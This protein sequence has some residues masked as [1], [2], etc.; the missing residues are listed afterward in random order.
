MIH[1][2]YVALAVREFERY[3]GLADRAVAQVSDEQFFAVPGNGDNS[4]AVIVKHMAGNMRSRWENF[5][6]SDG[7]KP[8]RN[9]DAEFI[10]TPDDTRASLWANWE[11]SWRILFSELRPL[12]DKDLSRVVTI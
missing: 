10:I 7:E 11:S 5:L 2:D 12:T 6:T 3:R 8:D 4:I 9:R 1:E